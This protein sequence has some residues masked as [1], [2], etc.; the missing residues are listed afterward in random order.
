[1]MKTKLI[2]KQIE[3]INV[4]CR[5]SWNTKDPTFKPVCDKLREMGYEIV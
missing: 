4:V 5:G 1:M 2:N 3:I